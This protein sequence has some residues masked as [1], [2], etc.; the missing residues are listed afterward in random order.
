M[1]APAKFFTVNHHDQT[2]HTVKPGSD[3]EK[4]LSQKAIGDRLTIK[5]AGKRHSVFETGVEARD[6]LVLLQL[7]GN[8]H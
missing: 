1:N 4:A 2:L 8:Q 6:F 7:D 3:L 5:V